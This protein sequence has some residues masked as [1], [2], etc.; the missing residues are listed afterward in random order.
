MQLLYDFSNVN[1]LTA[2][3]RVPGNL[4]GTELIC[5]VCDVRWPQLKAILASVDIGMA[6]E[7]ARVVP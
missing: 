3:F 1:I 2:A 5:I 7:G 4:S 6:E